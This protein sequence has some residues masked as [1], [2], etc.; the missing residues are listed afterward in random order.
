LLEWLADL[1]GQ[2]GHG[3]HGRDQTPAART[4]AIDVL[5][6]NESIASLDRTR[7]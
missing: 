3:V 4:Q 5:G 1:P 2:H 6:T 7:T